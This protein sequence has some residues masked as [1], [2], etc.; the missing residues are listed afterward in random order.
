MKACFIGHR[1]VANPEKTK[2]KLFA[3]IY[4][5][6]ENGVDTYLFGS[7]SEFDSLCWEVVTDLQIKFPNIRRINYGAPHEVAITSAEERRQYELFFSGILGHGV[8]FADYEGVV[9]SQKSIKAHRNAYIMRNQEMIDNSDVCVF[10]YNNDHLPPARKA[11]NIFLSDRQPKS[12]TAIAFRYATAKKKP[13]VNVF[14]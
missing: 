7:K 12:G 1:E 5:L 11:P 8:R 2:T 10:Y 13:I 6:I 3:V 14:E 4:D 9:V